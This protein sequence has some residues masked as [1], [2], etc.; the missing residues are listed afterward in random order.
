MHHALFKGTA[1][2]S[3]QNAMMAADN[4]RPTGRPC[5]RQPRSLA[6]PAV[7]LHEYQRSD[8]GRVVRRQDDRLGQREEHQPAGGRGQPKPAVAA[9]AP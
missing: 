5:H 1:Y 9:V 2:P 8:R 3:A 4:Q 7:D 6:I